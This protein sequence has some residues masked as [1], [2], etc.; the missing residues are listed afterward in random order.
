MTET[1]DLLAEAV[2]LSSAATLGPWEVRESNSVGQVWIRKPWPEFMASDGRVDYVPCGPDD[3]AFIAR[4]R[5][6][7]PELAAEAT[8]LREVI[9]QVSV[10]IQTVD[11]ETTEALQDALAE[12]VWQVI[13]LELRSRHEHLKGM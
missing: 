7:V 13:P 1:T 11:T 3:V 6:L 12:D 9:R 8:R 5:T 10:I 4:A 2:R